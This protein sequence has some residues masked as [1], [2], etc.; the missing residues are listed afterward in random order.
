MALAGVSKLVVH[1]RRRQHSGRA[2][3]HRI[4]RPTSKRQPFRKAFA[5]KPHARGDGGLPSPGEQVAA[6]EQSLLECGAHLP[7]IKVIA[8]GFGVLEVV[9]CFGRAFGRSRW[10]RLTMLVAAA[11]GWASD[12]QDAAGML[13]QLPPA[14]PSPGSHQSRLLPQISPRLHCAGQL[15]RNRRRSRTR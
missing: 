14:Q 5:Q 15:G 4:P 7:F 9:R 13:L 8:G 6:L 1:G 3:C 2:L 10:W 12:K 11:D